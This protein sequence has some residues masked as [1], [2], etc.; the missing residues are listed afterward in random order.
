MNIPMKTVARIMSVVPRGGGKQIKVSNS[1]YFRSKVS[2]EI[3]DLGINEISGIDSMKL[4]PREKYIF[5]Q[6]TELRIWLWLL[7]TLN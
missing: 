7:L 1:K 2:S 3:L 4:H 5:V 6:I